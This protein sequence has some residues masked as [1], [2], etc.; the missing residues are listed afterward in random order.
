VDALARAYERVSATRTVTLRLLR[1]LRRR[2][3]RTSPAGSSETNLA[4]LARVEQATPSLA[5]S[6]ALIRRALASTVS[7]RELADVGV[8]LQD[9]ETSFTRMSK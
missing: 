5:A 6:V 8:A 9:V 2:I 7:R 3:Q 1:G 4:F